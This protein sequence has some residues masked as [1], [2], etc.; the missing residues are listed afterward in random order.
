[1]TTPRTYARSAGGETAVTAASDPFWNWPPERRYIVIESG[2]VWPTSHGPPPYEVRGAKT[3]RE[4][5]D[6]G[7][8]P[9]F[10]CPCVGGTATI[11]IF[12]RKTGRVRHRQQFDPQ[13][14]Y[15]VYVRNRLQWSPWKRRG[16]G[17]RGV[18]NTPIMCIHWD[19]RSIF[20]REGE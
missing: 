15:G 14:G 4:V 11:T 18:N 8:D 6:M 10:D 2:M 17:R 3:L 5:K 19:A 1:V 9:W 12:D 20:P 13:R 7:F 16:A